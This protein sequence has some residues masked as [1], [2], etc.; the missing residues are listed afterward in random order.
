MRDYR[1]DSDTLYEAL[2]KQL[3]QV[4]YSISL[5][6]SSDAPRAD[7]RA[8]LQLYRSQEERLASQVEAIRHGEYKP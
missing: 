5:I 1:G 3:V 6:E 8:R 2:F 7:E 4:R